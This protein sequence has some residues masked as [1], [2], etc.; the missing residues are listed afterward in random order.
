MAIHFL[1]MHGHFAVNSKSI[2]QV[3]TIEVVR[4]LAKNF[5]AEIFLEIHRVREPE[6]ELLGHILRSGS[7][8]SCELAEL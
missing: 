5:L 8:Q 4:T 2:L 1:H 3:A 7:F 6:N